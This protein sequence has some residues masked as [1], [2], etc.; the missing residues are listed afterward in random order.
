MPRKK[1]KIKKINKKKSYSAGWN[2]DFELSIKTE[3]LYEIIA[4]TLIVLTIITILSFLNLASILGQNWLRI[5]KLTVGWAVIF[6]PVIFLG[7]SIVLFKHQKYPFKKINL[8][9]ILLF[10]VSTSAIFHLILTK[11]KISLAESLKGNG[12]GF[13][14]YFSTTPLYQWVGP[15]VLY[16]LY[17]ALLLISVL[18]IFNTSFKSLLDLIKNKI[19]P[20]EKI[21]LPEKPIIKEPI[22]VTDS[23]KTDDLK[24]DVKKTIKETFF[25]KV[26]RIKNNQEERKKKISSLSND[27]GWQLPPIN[28]LSE[29]ASRAESG[30]IRRNAEIIKKTL[31]HF[32]IEVEMGEVNIGPTVTQYTLKPATGIKLNRITALANDLALALAAHPIRIEAPIPG[33]SLV[34]IEVP[35]KV[36]AIVSLRGIIEFPEFQNNNANLLLSIGRDVAGTPIVDD[37]AKMPHLLIAGATGSG[38]TVC[39][40]SIIISLIYKNSPNKLKLILIDPKRVELTFY[41]DIPHLITPVVVD[42]VKTVSALKW[43]LA[44]MDRRYKLFEQTAKQNIIA[45]NNS[46]KDQ[47]L[48]YIVT[49]IDELAD[50]MMVSPQ[51]VETSIVRLSQMARATGIHLIIATQRPSVNVITGLIKANIT[52]R[53]AFST[54]SQVDSRTILDM[55][56]A[57]KLLGSGDMLYLAGNTA[58]PRR[59]QGAFVSE[60][61]IKRVSEFLKKQGKPEYNEEVISMEVKAKGIFGETPDD[62]LFTQ[63]AEVVINSGKASASLLQRRLKV[64]YARAARLIDLLEEKGI[65]GPA[66]GSKPREILV[67]SLE[68]ALYENDEISDTNNQKAQEENI[69][70][71]NFSEENFSD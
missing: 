19:K 55:A 41:N 16:I 14:G 38:K 40:N 45:Y 42:P 28:L 53:I 71:D 26:T 64:G 47:Q 54:A 31:E 37:L 51:E 24:E 66:E 57:E 7:L 13:L 10:L 60:E 21:N 6:L 15:F 29:S 68:E 52:Y 44:E 59:L 46:F 61:E 50:L 17:I 30:D 27:E 69:K 36:P 70:K 3:T 48:P 56:G 9:G 11:A 33:K 35:N 12:G 67:D 58:K 5:L 63:A 1:K 25:N 34:G 62:E 4:I 39:L 18:L 49:I 20:S 23:G 8:L 2:P 22:K 65:I 32:G 43:A